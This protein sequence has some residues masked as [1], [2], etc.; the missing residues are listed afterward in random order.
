MAR[1]DDRWM[2]LKR[3]L[4]EHHHDV[5]HKQRLAIKDGIRIHIKDDKDILAVVDKMDEL[6]RDEIERDREAR[7][8][9]MERSRHVH[10]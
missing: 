2:K 9:E 6:E 8:R 5:I 1:V 3:W 7:L 10:A 4:I